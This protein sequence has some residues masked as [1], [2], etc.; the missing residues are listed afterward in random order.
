MAGNTVF[1]KLLLNFR[2]LGMI[3]TVIRNLMS[4]ALKFTNIGGKINIVSS[5]HFEN[6]EKYIKLS[7][8]DNG[9][10]IPKDRLNGLFKIDKSESTI[11]TN[12]EEGTGLGLILCKEFIE[13]NNG[14]IFAESELGIGSK[15]HIILK[16]I[17]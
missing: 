5:E 14:K 9:V 17:V 7:I 3:K 11:G 10:G 8:I 12:N 6:N 16:A 4:N 1:K 13:K 2:F 15:F